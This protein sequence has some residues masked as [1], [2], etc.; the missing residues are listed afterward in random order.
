MNNNI[1]NHS[2]FKSVINKYISTYKRR[3]SKIWNA[4]HKR[5]YQI[6]KS[7]LDLSQ[8]TIYIDYYYEYIKLQK[9]SMLWELKHQE[10]MNKVIKQKYYAKIYIWRFI[11]I[12]CKIKLFHDDIYVN[13]IKYLFH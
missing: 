12:K 5:N 1:V 6:Y 10:G 7:T 8:N 11:L 9:K 4:V 13:I 3:K 2:V